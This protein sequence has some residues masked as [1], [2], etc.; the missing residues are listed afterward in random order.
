MSSKI[1]KL[2]EW[3]D[4]NLRVITLVMYNFQNLGAYLN[5]SIKMSSKM[6]KLN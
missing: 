5:N 2:N 6:K 3:L 1:K 4:T